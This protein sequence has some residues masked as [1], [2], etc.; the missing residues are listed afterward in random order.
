MSAHQSPTGDAVAGPFSRYRMRTELVSWLSSE[1][2]SHALTLNVNR[3]LS[4]HNMSIMF[5]NLCL[6]LDRICLGR[7]N[8][9]RSPSG[10]R[11]FAV[12]TIE[13]P[14]T[15]IHVHA[16]L[17]LDGWWRDPSPMHL[18]YQV[19]SIWAAITKG[20]GSIRLEPTRGQGWGAYI[21]KAIHAGDGEYLLSHDY[22][23]MR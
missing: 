10:E 15:N 20:S 5:G 19:R 3:S 2:C 17:R 18:E 4:A 8:A 14:E 21:T 6:D 1:R 11:L 7:K 9:H 22:H 12:G 23:S 16:A 13:H